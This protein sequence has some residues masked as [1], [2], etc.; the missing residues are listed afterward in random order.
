MLKLLKNWITEGLKGAKNI[1]ISLYLF[2]QVFMDKVTMLI[3]QMSYISRYAYS[4]LAE[5]SWIKLPTY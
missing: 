2:G 5:L 1:N 4:H 3:T